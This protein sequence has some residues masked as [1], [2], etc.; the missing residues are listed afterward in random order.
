MASVND[1]DLPRPEAPA[2]D[3]AAP[4][5]AARRRHRRSTL[6]LTALLL[7]VWFG[8][9]FVL[10]WFARDLDFAFFGWPFGFWVAAQ[11]GTIVFVVLIAVYARRMGRHDRALAEARREA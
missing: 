11:G 5:A 3:A 9:A 6:R 1:A 2:P 7:V 4:A 10:P 8:V